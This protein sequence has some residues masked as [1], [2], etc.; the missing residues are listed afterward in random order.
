[1]G[2]AWDEIEEETERGNND[3]EETFDVEAIIPQAY[4][5]MGTPFFQ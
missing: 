3:E 5:H 4:V 2:A 1:V